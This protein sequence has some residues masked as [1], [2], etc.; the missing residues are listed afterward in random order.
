MSHRLPTPGSDDGTWGTI[1]NDFLDQSLSPDGSLKPTA[2]I[3]SG[4]EQT[5]NKNQ[6]SG[7]AGLDTNA[8]VNVANLPTGT[9]SITVALG[10]DTRFA[11]SAAGTAGASLSATDAT[12]T[13]SRTPAGTATGDLSGS[14]PAP[15]VAK[16]NGI[17]L[18]G[19]APTGSGQVLTSTSTSATAWQTPTSGAVALTATSVQTTTYTASANQLIP[20]DA[21]SVSFT[22]TLPT[23]PAD[24]TRMIIKKIDGTT[25]AV[26]VATGGSDVFNKASG[27]TTG[28]LSL[29]NQAL[30]LQYASSGGIWYV[31]ADDLPLTQLDGRYVKTGTLVYNVKDYGA[32]G[33]GSTDDTT[34]VQN[35][36]NAA[37]TAGG[38]TVWFPAGTYMVTPTTSPAL[39]VPSDGIKL[40]GASRKKSVLKK[41][42]NGV[43]LSM[44]GPST[45][46]TGATHLHY[47][48]LESM[49]LHGNSKS[50]LILQLYYA[51]DLVF[52]DVYTLGN[53]DTAVDTAEFWDS[54]FENCVWESCGGGIGTSTPSIFLRNSA[55]S[56]GFGFSTDNVNQIYFIGCR[57]E[58]YT[59]G[60]LWI[61]QGVNNTNNPNGIYITDCK[62]ET[63][64]IQGG[65][66]FSVSSACIGINVNSLYMYA[67]NFGTG[68]STP[69]NVIQWA[70]S[71]SSLENVELANGSVTT[72]NSGIDLFSGDV[73]TLRNVIGKY[74]TAPTGNHIFFEASSTGDFI[75]ENSY[76]AAGSQYGGTI[77]T[78]FLSGS[79]LRQI[80][81]PVSDAS[82]AHGPFNG[83]MA[84]DT[85]DFSLYVRSAAIWS[86]FPPA[87]R[88]YYSKPTGAIAESISRMTNLSATLAPTSGN[89]YLQAIVLPASAVVGHL[90]FATGGTAAGTPTHWWYGLLDSNRNL[91]AVTADQTTTAF[92]ANTLSSLP[93]ATIASGSATSFTTTYTG[94]YYVG[95]MMTA[96]TMPNFIGTNHVSGD[97]AVIAASPALQGTSTTAMTT[98]PAFPFQGAALTTGLQALYYCYA[99]L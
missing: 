56:S 14:Y 17:A 75:I 59:I 51:D 3:A 80:A 20:A 92:A 73:A 94:L 83:T 78:K 45:D 38:G 84:L 40:V 96:T 1:L 19:T 6:A 64:S 55:A 57:W 60:S 70:P 49:T 58:G 62:M 67:G 30:T 65:P 77:P 33:N 50:G 35:A 29:Q 95:L 52:R 54:R 31:S 13:N 63:S 22:I 89:L 37:S 97:N 86:A 15:T 21:T 93:I 12:T 23:A 44:S 39:N 5:V 27:S 90:A 43:L 48:S 18:P 4:A 98:P 11:G 34:A 10:S 76:S 72:I 32:T 42:A 8:N 25:N 87:L 61:Q 88:E 99:G 26:T 71:K 16:V 2:V 36:I 82:F 7:Y 74:V 41:T 69:V 68:Y 66:L 53:T 91:L 46:T 81:G 47:C 85:T 28:T 9:T 79:P 24:K